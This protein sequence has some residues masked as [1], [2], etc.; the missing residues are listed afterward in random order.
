[1]FKGKQLKHKPARWI[2]P[3]ALLVSLLL[4][5]GAAV[6]GTVAFIVAEDEPVENT[7]V[8]SHVTTYVDETV[9]GTAKTDVKIKNTG[10]TTAYLRAAVVVT[11]QDAD[12][13]ILGQ[14]PDPGTDYTIE[15]QLSDTQGAN[16]WIEG[17]DGFYYWTSP[18]L[19]D[20]E[21]ADNCST[22]VLIKRCEA[23]PSKTVG[24]ST[25]SL[26]VEILSSG[27]Q[28]VPTSVVADVWESGIDSVSADGVLTI[29]K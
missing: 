12:G 19:S 23:G 20:D 25:Y 6:G 14:K 8:P 22:G 2:R 24:S 16:C 11:W 18:V 1:M 7:F 10:D 29:K 21:A 5:V 15:Y 4:I 26:T 17:A 28:S 9:S 3:R 27:I 13:N